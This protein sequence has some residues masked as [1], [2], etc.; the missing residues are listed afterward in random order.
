MFFDLKYMPNLGK[1]TKRTLGKLCFAQ[2][3]AHRYNDRPI[4]LPVTREF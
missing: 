4:S 1:N 3:Y 2:I